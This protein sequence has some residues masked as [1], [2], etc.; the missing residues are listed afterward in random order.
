MK[1]LEGAPGARFCV[2]MLKTRV[3][4]EELSMG[5]AAEGC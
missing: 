1:D 3:G 5:E 4:V 2:E